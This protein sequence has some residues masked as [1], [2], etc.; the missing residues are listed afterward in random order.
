MLAARYLLEAKDIDEMEMERCPNCWKLFPVIEL[1]LHSPICQDAA[2]KRRR[3][4]T[5]SS[6][7]SSSHLK[8]ALTDA[9]SEG[10]KASLE[11]DTVRA[12]PAAIPIECVEQCPHCLDLF[13]LDVLIFHAETCSLA[14][15][16]GSTSSSSVGRPISR[17]SVDGEEEEVAAAVLPVSTL[18]N[19]SMEQC[20]YCSEL[21]PVTELIT[22]CAICNQSTS[23]SSVGITAG[24]EE[25]VPRITMVDVDV[26]SVVAKRARYTLEPF[27]KSAVSSLH[28]VEDAAWLQHG[29]VEESSCVRLASGATVVDSGSIPDRMDELEQCVHCLKEFPISELVTHA[30]TCSAA[31][32]EAGTE[33]DL[34]KLTYF[35][36]FIIIILCTN[37]I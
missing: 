6:I 14:S 23:P 11:S 26:D 33:V 24:F 29:P 12:G 5:T 8:E 17:T 21:L 13:P 18:R 4:S 30:T 19:T 10:R 35:K 7:E 27:E 28:S 2:A 37:S 1:P 9:E 36:L 32:K 31:A 22:H 3:S 15:S 16:N 20:P 34:Q 25:A